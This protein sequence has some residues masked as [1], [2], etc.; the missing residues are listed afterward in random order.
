MLVV[1]DLEEQQSRDE[2]IHILNCL[3]AEPGDN[4]FDRARK[5]LIKFHKAGRWNTVENSDGV[6]KICRGNHENNAGCQYETYVKQK[7]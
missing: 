3:E 7:E 5:A 6:L 2:L 1:L 4:T